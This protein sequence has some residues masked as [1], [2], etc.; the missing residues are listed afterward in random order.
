M[1]HREFMILLCEAVTQFC[2]HMNGEES[3]CFCGDSIIARKVVENGTWRINP[4]VVQQ[5]EEALKNHV[6]L[7][8]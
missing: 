7:S 8:K 5:V 3:P 6:I 2:L 4:S 1:N